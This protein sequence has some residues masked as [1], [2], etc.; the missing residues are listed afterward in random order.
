MIDLK[1]SSGKC[2]ASIFMGLAAFTFPISPPQ[3][4]IEQAI[5]NATDEICFLEN[6]KDYNKDL[7]ALHHVVIE[8]ANLVFPKYG[9]LKA[10]YEYRIEDVLKGKQEFPDTGFEWVIRY[11]IATKIVAPSD[12]DKVK[13][14]ILLRIDFMMGRGEPN[15][16]MY[17]DDLPKILEDL[18]NTDFKSGKWGKLTGI[19]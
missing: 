7:Q 11:L 3:K 1:T 9:T 6:R 18:E 5:I 19:I 17:Y 12:Y 13:E 10:Y 14:L 15:T 4:R 8:N 16:K 2:S